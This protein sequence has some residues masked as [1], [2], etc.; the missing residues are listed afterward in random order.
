[1][2]YK[3]IIFLFIVASLSSCKGD[4]STE[5]SLKTDLKKT[6]FKSKHYIIKS[7]IKEN[8]KDYIFGDSVNLFVGDEAIEEAKK[9]GEADYDMS[10]SG[11]TIYY[12]N[13][14]VYLSNKK[15]ELIKLELNEIVLIQLVDFSDD[16]FRFK[17]VT[18]TEFIKHLKNKPIMLVKTRNGVI[19]GMMEKYIP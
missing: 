16:T 12:L 3:K 15:Q 19:I 8:G 11:D 18:L 17:K 10:E 5:Q 9:F 1:M 13:N 4:K 2:H 14:D 7:H 6:E